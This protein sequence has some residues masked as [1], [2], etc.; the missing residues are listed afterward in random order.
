MLVS[1]RAR[2]QIAKKLR[3]LPVLELDLPTLALVGAPN[4]GKSSLVQVRWAGRLPLRCAA[5]HPCLSV[6]QLAPAACAQVLS[7]GTPEVC[8]YPFTT[9]SIKMGHFFLDARKHQVCESH[10]SAANSALSSA[11]FTVGWSPSTIQWQLLFGHAQQSPC[12]QS[13]RSVW[14]AQVV[15]GPAWTGSL[16][17]CRFPQFTQSITQCLSFPL[18]MLLPATLLGRAGHRHARA[19]GPP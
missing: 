10:F 15:S 1:C 17:A 18:L 5:V 16:I 9:R 3:T 2:L 6:A 19:A 13:V 8:N 7:S 14:L 12:H 4:V 11:H